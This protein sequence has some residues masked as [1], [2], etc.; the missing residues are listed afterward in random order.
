MGAEG[1]C[2]L[3]AALRGVEV[4]PVWVE[5]SISAGIPGLDI[6]GMPDSAVLEARSRVRCALRSSD[7]TLPRA[8]VT[9]NLRPGGIRKTGTSFDLPIAVALLVATGQLPASVLENTLYAG[10][11]ALNGEVCPVRGEV[12]YAQ[13]AA[14]LGVRLVTSAH[15][16]A[17]AAPLGDARG[18]TSLGQLKGGADGLPPLRAHGSEPG[19]GAGDAPDFSQVVDQELAKRALTIAAA[20]RHG[21]LMVGPPGAGK[22]ML[23]R[24]VPTILPPL[25][26]Q[27]AADVMLVHSVAG[28]P[29][30][31]VARGARPFRAPHHSISMAG[32][33]GG[34]RP[35]TPGEVSLAHHGV[36][37]LDELPE[38]ARTSLQALRQPLEDREVRITRVDGTY[39]FPCDFQLVAAA[40]PCPCGHLGDPGH[41]CTCPPARVAAYQARIGGPLMDRIDLV[42]DVPRP[43]ATKVIDG[44]PGTSS[45]TMAEQVASALEF[46]S[47]REAREGES[48]PAS[49]ASSLEPTA[50]ATFESLATS[51]HLGGRAIARVARVARTIA[52][53][54]G[55]ERASEQDVVE[56]LGFRSRSDA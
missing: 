27:E 37:Y 51:L 44:R 36:L 6:V 4:T 19:E 31:E 55:R 30:D 21:V 48:A 45:A 28:L 43:D 49:P 20:G 2:A 41:E 46:R 52:D 34:G 3:T 47:W 1:P 5:V 7:F 14:E 10:E 23:A 18:V 11:L 24:R 17:G 25:D 12:A 38:F 32:L 33:V 29:V 35:V 50:R 40:N 42:V 54:A 26:E 16:S 13:L 9:I 56:A 53:L 15:S 8:H 39:T 22:T